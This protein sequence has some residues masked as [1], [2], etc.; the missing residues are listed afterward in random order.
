[1]SKAKFYAVR[2][3]R[4]I[5]IFQTWAE[6]EAQ[7]KGFGGAVYKSFSTLREAKAFLKQEPLPMLEET[8]RA[9]AHG[10]GTTTVGCVKVPMQAEQSPIVQVI[11]TKDDLSVC[12]TPPIVGSDEVVAYIDGSFNKAKGLVGSG[13]VIFTAER[14]EEFSFGTSESAYAKFWNVA[15]ELLG[16]MYVV[17]YAVKLEKKQCTLYYDYMGIEMWATGQWKANNVLTQQYASYMQQCKQRLLLHFVKVAAHT[18]DYYNERAD[19]L[20]KQGAEQE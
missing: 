11:K 6:C 2:V 14:R 7:V 15:G 19:I 9:G 13:G 16:A 20:A 10:I 5:G 1:M 4:Q 18:G 3:G 8:N 12:Q 17:A